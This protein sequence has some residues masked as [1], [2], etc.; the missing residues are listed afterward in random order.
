[1]ATIKKHMFTIGIAVLALALVIYG[2][3]TFYPDPTQECYP[4]MYS[5]DKSSCVSGGGEWTASDGSR[6]VK[7]EG[8]SG[9]CDYTKKCDPIRENY[10]RNLALI[11]YAIGIALLLY[12][13]KGKKIAEQTT[14][15][16]VGGA[17]LIMVYGTV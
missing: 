3:N 12:G 6:P 4:K 15:G 16:F 9:Y 7:I 1:M 8:E 2:F 13:I 14:A 11:S 5:N 10:S 17:L